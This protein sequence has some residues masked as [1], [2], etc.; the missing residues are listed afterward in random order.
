MQLQTIERTNTKFK[1]NI[2]WKANKK[3]KNIYIQVLIQQTAMTTSLKFIGRVKLSQKT[4]CQNRNKSGKAA[5][6]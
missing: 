3:N 4:Q 6:N 2:E 5:P 1:F